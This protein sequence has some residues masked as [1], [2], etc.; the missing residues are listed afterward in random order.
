GGRREQPVDRL[1]PVDAAQ[2]VV[3]GYEE[4]G[5]HEDLPVA[6]EGEEGERAEDVEVGL[7]PAA[8]EMDQQ[9]RHEHLPRRDGVP[10][11]RPSGPAYGEDGRKRR[12][13]TAEE[14]GGPD[15]KVGEAPGP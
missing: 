14:Y 3:G 13:R 12:D 2:E 8:G 5:G 7:D 11:E 10:C 4:R 15:V 6:I 1:R 9:G